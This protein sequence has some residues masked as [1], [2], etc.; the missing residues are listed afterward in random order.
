LNDPN[1]LILDALFVPL[2]L[3]GTSRYEQA[4]QRVRNIIEIWKSSKEPIATHLLG[5]SY[6]NL[7]YIGMYTSTMN[8]RYDSYEFTKRSIEYFKE[9]TFPQRKS[10]AP[11]IVADI[12]S[13][14]CL[15][16]EGATLQEFDR[17]LDS[18]R[19]MAKYVK[20]TSHNMYYGYDDLIACEIAFYKNQV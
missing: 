4:E 8:H 14:A 20:K 2:L 17:F 18:A 9:S 11:F 13:F 6:S 5:I 10:T 12:R 1:Y 7:A 3:V 15:V 19:E 16:G